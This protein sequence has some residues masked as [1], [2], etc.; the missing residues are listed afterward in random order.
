MDNEYLDKILI[1]IRDNYRGRVET[2]ILKGENQ[3]INAGNWPSAYPYLKGKQYIKV[4]D[5]GYELIELTPEGER[6]LQE[7]G[8]SA[9]DHYKNETLQVAKDSRKY[10]LLA[11]IVSIIS[12]LVS[13]LLW[14]MGDFKK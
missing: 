10:A 13:I 4:I 2:N 8:F 1:T 6:F 14:F 12:I 11:F 9:K 5:Y 7:G 3:F